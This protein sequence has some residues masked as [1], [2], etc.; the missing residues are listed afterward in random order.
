MFKRFIAPSSFYKDVLVVAIPFMLQQLITSSLNLVDNLMVGQLGGIALGGVAITNRFFMIAVFATFGVTGA[1][2]IFIAQYFGAKDEENIKQAF[3]YSLTSVYLVLIPFVI[4]GLIAPQSVLGFFSQDPAILQV[5][6]EYIRIVAFAFIPLGLTFAL[7]SAMRSVGETKIPL[8]ISIVAVSMNAILNYILIFGH[9]GFPR[10]GVAGA[11]YATVISRTFEMIAMLISLKIKHFS[12]STKVSQIFHISKYNLKTIT[13]KALPLT[14]NEFLWAGGMATL[15]K[16]Y[17]TRGSEVIAG[18]SIASTTAD[19]FFVLF[20]GMAV[21]TT[22][23]IS[24]PL[25]ANE[26]DEARSRGYY[27]LGFSAVLALL[28]G[29]VMFFSSM[30]V[31]QLYDVTLIEREIASSILRIMSVMFVI[32][33]STAECYFI[34]RAGGDM[35]STLIMD[36]VFMWVVNVPVVFVVAYYTN[37]PILAVYLAGQ[38]TDFLKLMVSYALVKKEKWVKNLTIQ[39]T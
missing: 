30:I 33:M 22:V 6:G 9:F 20:G 23:M 36:S 38:S 24:Q 28:L 14:I 25:G 3:R 34:L 13:I 18:L 26:L 29:S 15:F 39:N 11:A 37:W 21:A 35:K 32:Y 31:P 19:L 10:L 4:L 17:A 12:F 16:L 27:M 8:Y 7:A 1:A 2:S 5:G